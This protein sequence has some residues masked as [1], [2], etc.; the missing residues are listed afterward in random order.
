MEFRAW[1][2][3]YSKLVWSFIAKHFWRRRYSAVEEQEFYFA[4]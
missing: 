4:N 2:K 1:N 3:S